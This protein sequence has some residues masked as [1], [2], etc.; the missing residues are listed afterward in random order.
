MKSEYMKEWR[1]ASTWQE[2]NEMSFFH[3]VF[4]WWCIERICLPAMSGS[5]PCGFLLSGSHFIFYTLFKTLLMSTPPK[6]GGSY[7]DLWDLFNQTEICVFVRHCC[8]IKQRCDLTPLCLTSVLIELWENANH[9]HEGECWFLSLLPLQR[10]RANTSVIHGYLDM[11]Y[12]P[13]F[14]II[15]DLTS[16]DIHSTSSELLAHHAVLVVW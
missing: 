2:Y 16:Q 7:L 1:S 14:Y 9:W 5:D 11:I 4:V 6:Q 13:R 10:I 8:W 12:L 15:R 3:S